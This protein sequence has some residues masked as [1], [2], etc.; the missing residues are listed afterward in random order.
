MMLLSLNNWALYVLGFE[1][2]LTQ[3]GA[4]GVPEWSGHDFGINTMFWWR[5]EKKNNNSWLS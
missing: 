1:W 3:D 5:E 4:C 2:K